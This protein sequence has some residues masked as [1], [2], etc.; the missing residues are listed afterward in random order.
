MTRLVLTIII[1]AA[2]L[3]GA[4]F[5]AMDRIKQDNKKGKK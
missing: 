5:E 4:V 1:I 3:K 2:I